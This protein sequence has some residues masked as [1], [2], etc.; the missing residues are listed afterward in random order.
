MKLLPGSHRLVILTG[1][2]QWLLVTIRVRFPVAKPDRS[3]LETRAL[4]DTK[5]PAS[6][7]WWMFFPFLIG[8][9]SETWRPQE[10][11]HSLSIERR[12]SV[13]KFPKF[14]SSLSK[15]PLDSLVKSSSEEVLEPV[16]S[17][18]LDGI[19]YS[20][21]TNCLLNCIP[22]VLHTQRLYDRAIEMPNLDLKRLLLF[23]SSTDQH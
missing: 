8:K 2:S 6:S 1:I 23:I 3:P 9:C 17:Y 10:C 14:R 11:R 15:E 21:V 13:G 12:L 7:D 18:S 22:C 19:C 20:W 4:T 16:K 5:L